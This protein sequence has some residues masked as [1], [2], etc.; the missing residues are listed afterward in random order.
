MVNSDV[1]FLTLFQ[2]SRY[3]REVDTQD[4]G[5]R[6]NRKEVF[7]VA[8]VAFAFK[9]DPAFA[10]HFLKPLDSTLHHLLAA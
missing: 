2:R 8:M 10:A 3:A 1:S 5:S 6:S 9:Y 7:A 4:L